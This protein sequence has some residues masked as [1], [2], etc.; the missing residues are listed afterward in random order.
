MP[1][2]PFKNTETVYRTGS[3]SGF[4]EKE[5]ECK[6]P[7]TNY[8]IRLKNNEGKMQYLGENGNPTDFEHAKRFT[9][10]EAIKLVNNLKKEFKN[11]Q[12]FSSTK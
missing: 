10:K 1:H 3:I 6:P 8:Y 11:I 9:E 5:E 7:E 2:S 4:R 12:R